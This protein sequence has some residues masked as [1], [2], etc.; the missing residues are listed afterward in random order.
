MQ[1]TFCF[2]RPNTIIFDIWF[3][4]Q[5]NWEETGE[6]FK[7]FSLPEREQAFILSSAVYFCLHSITHRWVA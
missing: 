5:E 6:N 3:Q 1:K 2:V 7:Y 4:T